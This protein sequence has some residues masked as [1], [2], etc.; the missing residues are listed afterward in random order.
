MARIG[1]GSSFATLSNVDVWIVVGYALPAYD[2]EVRRLF[3][4]ASHDQHIAIYDPSAE[5]VAS[6]FAEV[7]PAASFELHAGLKE[8]RPIIIQG[9]DRLLPDTDPKR[10][11]G[12]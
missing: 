1:L 2:T 10:L 3:S 12:A 9:D 5:R 4:A 11:V 6:A 8:D 7:C